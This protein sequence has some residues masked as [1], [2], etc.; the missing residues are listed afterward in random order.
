MESRQQ[1]FMVNFVGN[2]GFLKIMP[3]SQPKFDGVVFGKANQYFTINVTAK[4]Q[5]N[6]YAAKLFIDDQEVIASK[7]FKKRG[8]FFG[9][10]KGNGNYDRFIF[11]IPE[12]KSDPNE[13]DAQDLKLKGK[14]MGEIRIVFFKAVDVWKKAPPAGNK[15]REKSQNY[16]S[17]KKGYREV[18]ASDCKN[19]Q[20]RSLSVGYG[21]TFQIELPKGFDPI[22]KS[23][24]HK[25]MIKISKPNFDDPPID[26]I[27]LRYSSVS[28]M[29]GLGLLNPLD[30]EH[31][32]YFPIDFVKD[33]RL[34]L[35][36]FF[37]SLADKKQTSKEIQTRLEETFG[38][39]MPELIEG[40]IAAL[41]KAVKSRAKPPSSEE[42]KNAVLSGEFT[43]FCTEGPLGSNASEKEERKFLGKRSGPAR[44]AP[45]NP[46]EKQ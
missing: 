6:P 9:F 4:D 24:P 44:Q 22:E 31:L 37:Q 40:G 13:D 11:S 10:K 32:K 39:K 15:S 26:L 28:T 7:T 41:S 34:I 42:I 36:F 43:R 5:A 20:S 14:M 25:D 23:G 17:E 16:S 21:P 27:V 29:I 18:P 8:N 45:K 2:D 19:I 1:Q 38:V 3:S 46:S 33:N 12:F 35:E 30:P